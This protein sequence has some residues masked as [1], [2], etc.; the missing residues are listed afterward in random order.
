ML[1]TSFIAPLV[2]AAM[3]AISG[4][5]AETH[6]ITFDNRCGKGTV[7]LTCC[8]LFPYILT[9]SPQ[10]MLKQNF[11]TLS[12]GGAY[13]H[14]GPFTAAIAYLDTGNCG[15]SGENCVRSVYAS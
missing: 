14:S 3:T 7:R 12:T 6:T 8:H 11:Q 2:L 15:A 10:P 1:S 13:T 9:Q 4:V 5:Y